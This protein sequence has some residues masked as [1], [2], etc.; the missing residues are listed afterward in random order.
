[1]ADATPDD[2][3]C[4]IGDADLASWAHA[5]GDRVAELIR[6]QLG[7]ALKPANGLGPVKTLVSQVPFRMVHLLSNAPAPVAD[8]YAAWLGGPVKVHRVELRSPIDYDAVFKVVDAVLAGEEEGLRRSSGGRAFHLS[9]GTPTMTAVW[10]LLGKSRYPA[11]FYQTHKDDVIETEI[12]FDLKVDYLPSLL[13]ASDALLESGV[14]AS[15]PPASFGFVTARDPRMREVISRAERIAVRDVSVMILGES[16]VGKELFARGVHQHSRRAGKPFVAINCAA[17]PKDLLESE[18]FGHV[19]GAFTGADKDRD[20]AFV[21]AHGGTLFLDEVGECS[22]DMQAKL[23]RSL[24]PSG[25]DGPTVR[26]F[27]RLGGDKDQTADVRIIAAT[28]R[29]LQAEIAAGRFR[30]DLFYRLAIFSLRIPPLRER[31]HDIPLLA[32]ELLGTINANFVAGEPGY[33]HKELSARTKKFLMRQPW[34]GNVRQLRNVLV[35]ASVLSDAKTLE[36]AFVQQLLMEAD[37]SGRRD[38]APAVGDDF[39]LEDHLDRQRRRYIIDAM[40]EAGGKV[41]AASRLLGYENY[42]T[43]AQQLKRWKIQWKES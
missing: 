3:F 9:P 21:A 14:A 39:N 23:L 37:P 13:H 40:R 5:G 16:G 35:Q 11:R 6:E 32:D 17:V 30:E 29:D 8:G 10:V 20:G 42:Q 43:L 34:P 2:L 18:L 4:W 36:P 1:M 25:T 22:L 33:V 19:K 38:V 27:R 28:N 26:R 24:Q 12:P 15:M 7:R 31:P 41:T